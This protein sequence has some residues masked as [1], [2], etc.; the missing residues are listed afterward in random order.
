MPAYCESHTS[1]T[2]R[3]V[4]QPRPSSHEICGVP[5]HWVYNAANGKGKIMRQGVIRNLCL[6][7]TVCGLIAVPAFGKKKHAHA[8]LP[9]K[10]LDAETI[11]IDNQT[12]MAKVGD[13]AFDELS[14]WGRF[15]IVDSP[16]KADLVF[17][18]STAEYQRGAVTTGKVDEDGNLRATTRPAEHGETILTVVD[19]REGTSLWTDSKPWGGLLEGFRSATRSLIKE[20]RHRIEEQEAAADPK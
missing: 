20:I 7:L 14:K 17:L 8:P 4:R 1:Q 3:C 13:R 16:K 12:G 9:T 19:A 15:R 11:Y 2:A 18:F 5:S 6:L 10:V